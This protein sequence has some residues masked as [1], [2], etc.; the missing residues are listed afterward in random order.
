MTFFD[1]R[2][3]HFKSSLGLILIQLY[4]DHGIPYFKTEEMKS[5]P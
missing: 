2:I 1:F 4:S 5:T 3:L